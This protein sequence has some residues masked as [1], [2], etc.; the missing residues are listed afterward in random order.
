M[1]ERA[2]IVRADRL[3]T[4]HFDFAIVVCTLPFTDISSLD[5]NLSVCGEVTVNCDQVDRSTSD[6]TAGSEAREFAWPKAFRS[7]RKR[8]FILRPRVTWSPCRPRASRFLSR[9]ALG[10][11]L[12]PLSPSPSHP[13]CYGSSR[14]VWVKSLPHPTS[15]FPHPKKV[16]SFCGPS[17]CGIRDSARVNAPTPHSCAVT[18]VTPKLSLM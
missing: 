2:L 10:M 7:F 16:L 3:G 1:E 17:R 4:K 11:R 13:T 6:C 5:V 14:C 9:R 15:R 8:S 18:T 12:R